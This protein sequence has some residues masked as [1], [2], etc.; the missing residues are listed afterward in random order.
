MIVCFDFD[1]VI[2]QNNTLVILIERFYHHFKDIKNILE[3]LEHKISPEYFPIFLKNV[4]KRLKGMRWEEIENIYQEY[5]L[6][7]G[8]LKCF[9]YIKKQGHKLFVIS[10]NDERLINL[11]LQKKNLMK[12]VD[13]VYGIK[14]DTKSG[15]L[16]GKLLHDVVEKVNIIKSFHSKNVVYIGDGLTDIP[17]FFSVKSIVFCPNFFVK[18]ILFTTRELKKRM[19]EGNLILIEKHDL[20]KILK[21]IPSF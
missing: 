14:L 8:T 4:V 9:K 20:S 3:F 16:T 6:M 15:R 13:R 5:K 21:F 19:E 17:V 10:E 2:I 12:Y 7:P 1:N 11:Y 18:S